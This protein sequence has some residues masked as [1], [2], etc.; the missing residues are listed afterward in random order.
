MKPVPRALPFL[1]GTT[2]LASL[3][4]V[5][6]RYLYLREAMEW[7]PAQDPYNLSFDFG[8][9][10]LILV[11]IPSILSVVP[12]IIVR[13]YAIGSWLTLAASLLA[14]CMIYSIIPAW[15]AKRYVTRTDDDVTFFILILGFLYVPLIFISLLW[16]SL[17]Q[18]RSQPARP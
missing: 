16:V 2:V 6:G 4:Y 1:L 13:K 11:L 5:M 15:H 3:V 17:A 12:G 10:G 18:R 8:W 9:V 14:S 7:P